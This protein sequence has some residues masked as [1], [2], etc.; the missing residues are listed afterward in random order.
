PRGPGLPALLLLAWAAGAAVAMGRLLA[1]VARVRREGR[2]ARPLRDGPAAELLAHLAR[3]VGV[4]RPI[5]LLEG[6]ADAMPLTWGIRRPRILLPTGTEA[7]PEGRL[8]AVLLHELAHVRRRDCLAQIAAEAACALYWFNPLAWAA[9]RRLKLESEHACDDQVLLAGAP[10]CDYADHLLDVARALRPP[11]RMAVAAVAMARPTQL[12]TRL[13]AV[14]SADRRRGPV[15]RRLAVP[16]LL[17]SALMVAGVAALTPDTAEAGQ[18]ELVP[19]AECPRTGSWHH[20]DQDNDGVWSVSW[21]NRRGCSGSARIRDGVRFG[22]GGVASVAEGGELRLELRRGGDR[23]EVEVRAGA[24]GP[25]RTLRVNGRAMPWDRAADEWLARAIAV[26]QRYTRYGEKAAE[27]QAA[28]EVED[29][30]AAEAAAAARSGARVRAEAERAVTDSPRR[31]ETQRVIE[32]AAAEAVRSGADTTRSRLLPPLGEPAFP[33]PREEARG[34]GDGDWTTEMYRTATHDGVDC[35]STLLARNAYPTAN[36][37]AIARIDPGGYVTLSERC[38]G[39]PVRSVRITPAADG[40]P[41]YAWSGD[42]AGREAWL[43][44]L[45]GYFG[46][47]L[48]VRW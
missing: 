9:L 33:A 19:A 42:P 14:L 29:A 36:K 2:T 43:A 7:W 10:G 37:R 23:T 32:I 3:R 39:G 12:R 17:A 13:Q 31:D 27:A 45:L 6:D 25:R 1:S 47:G 5:V 16:A 15:P 26:L 38:G 11:R 8:E 28:E 30:A 40:S 46:R 4:I 22:P 48:P 24:R 44:D 18:P 35:V 34:R 20:T 21:S 41:R